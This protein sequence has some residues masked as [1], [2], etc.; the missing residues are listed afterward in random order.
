MPRQRRTSAKAARAASSVLRSKATSKK[1]ETA[2]ASAL[3]QAAPKP[4]KRS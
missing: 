2:A 1:S 3:S 4:R